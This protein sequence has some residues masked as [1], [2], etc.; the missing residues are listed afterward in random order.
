MSRPGR[1]RHPARLLLP[2][3]L[4]AVLPVRARETRAAEDP[5]AG[6]IRFYQRHL[7]SLRHVRCRFHPSCS[8]FATQAIARY[9]L[10]EGSARAADRLM[11][12]NPSAATRHPR[13]ERGLLADPV[14]PDPASASGLRAPA[15]VLPEARVEPIPVS[16]SLAG[17][18]RVRI[19]ETLEFARLLERRG[20][21]EALAA[22]FQRAGFLADTLA[23]DAWAFARLG[24]VY[25]RASQWRASERNYLAAAMVLPEARR[26]PLALRAAA[27]RFSAGQFA[28]CAR[29]LDDPAFASADSG[30]AHAALAAR[31]KALQG[32]CLLA[33][34]DWAGAQARFE[35]AEPLAAATG[36]HMPFP[37]LRAAAREGP[38][39]P[40]RSPGLSATLS[41][42]LPG[43]GQAYTGNTQDGLRH[44]VFNAALIYS[45]VALTRAEELPGAVVVA[46]IAL[47]FYLGNVLGA[48]FE[49]Q[50]FNQARRLE[51]LERALAHAP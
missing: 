38:D 12:C 16:C 28:A 48:R 40:R 2:M 5:T 17:E 8:E 34:G 11:R 7:S 15:W 1:W 27:T 20:E 24:E 13:D 41:A 9:G 3:L 29:L 37:R 35:R 51:L 39:L 42:I 23:A 14:D 47:P 22:E 32:L 19:A 25:D 50:R 6:A 33:R 30:G 44:L 21:L 49:A 45:V 31:A 43:A 18:K 10:V 26:E 36:L 4:V 46:G